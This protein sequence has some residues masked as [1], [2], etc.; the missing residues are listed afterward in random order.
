MQV[1]EPTRRI[2][3]PFVIL[4]FA[5]LVTPPILVTAVVVGTHE[6][7][8]FVPE[9]AV[10]ILSLLRSASGTGAE[11]ALVVAAGLPA[12]VSALC[13][14]SQKSQN[15]SLAGKVAL[16]LLAVGIVDAFVILL[17]LDPAAQGRHIMG[18]EESIKLM[19]AS[20][21]SSLKTSFTYL[22]LLAGLKIGVKA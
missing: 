20:A 4:I 7:S 13:F 5:G 11:M 21:S 17:F 3:T 6:F 22:M 10:T 16:S 19:Q 18:G 15:L 8:A 9:W 2:L 1:S 12:L 14:T